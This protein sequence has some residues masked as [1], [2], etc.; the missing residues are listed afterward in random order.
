CGG[1]GD[2]FRIDDAQDVGS[3]DMNL[4]SRFES[5]AALEDFMTTPTPEL[6]ADMKSV[7]GDILVLGVGGKMGPTLARMA[8]RALPLGQRVIGVARFSERGLRESLSRHGVETIEADLLDPKALERLP[9]AQ[10]VIFMAGRKFG[11]T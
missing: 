8:K 7:K 4:P 3:K 1:R 5:I 9:K 11:A 10:N 2:G 6:V